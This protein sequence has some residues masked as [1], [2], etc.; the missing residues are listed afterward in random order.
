VKHELSQHIGQALRDLLD[1]ADDAGPLPE[2]ALDPP[3]QA[4]HG[5]FAC[6]AAMLLAKRL[7]QPPRAIAE[8]LV[9]RLGDA[10]GT[11]TAPAL[12][13]TNRSGIPM[14]SPTTARTARWC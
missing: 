2:F 9:T 1:A 14:R 11:R 12:A 10:G 3:R 8:E 13:G 7:R 5:D 4:E 6:N